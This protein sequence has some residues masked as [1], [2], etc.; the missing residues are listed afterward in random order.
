[1]GALKHRLCYACPVCSGRG[2]HESGRARRMEVPHPCT[3]GSGG[4]RV[5]GRRVR[6]VL[7]LDGEKAKPP[8]PHTADA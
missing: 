5:A 7:H 3:T 8:P 4:C 2:S 1:M 6:P